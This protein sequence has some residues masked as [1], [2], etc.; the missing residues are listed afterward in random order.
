[1]GFEEYTC[2]SEDTGDKYEPHLTS[3]YLGRDEHPVFLVL[4]CPK[5]QPTVFR[6]RSAP[7]PAVGPLLRYKVSFYLE[8]TGG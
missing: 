4:R 3:S 1:M 2:Y 8:D 6:R 5:F 7:L